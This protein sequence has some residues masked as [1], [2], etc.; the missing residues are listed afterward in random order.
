MQAIKHVNTGARQA[1]QAREHVYKQT[2]QAREKQ[3]V[4]VGYSMVTLKENY[5]SE[6]RISYII[7][8]FNMDCLKYYES[9]KT[10]H[11]YDNIFEEG[12]IPIIN[13]PT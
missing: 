3:V 4:A 2:R 5:V 10:K 1:R 9:D 11:F 7:G 8:D 6:K 13:R 12:I